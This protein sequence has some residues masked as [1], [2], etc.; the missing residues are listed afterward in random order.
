MTYAVVIL[1]GPEI[2]ITLAGIEYDQWGQ[3]TNHP[4]IV[5]DSWAEGF[6]QATDQGFKQAL[7][8][9]SGTVFVNWTEWNNLLKK[10]P[11]QGLIAHLIW[12]PNSYPYID[13]QCWFANLNNFDIDDLNSNTVTS[14]NPI[15]SDKNLHD[16]YTPLWIKADSTTTTYPVTQFGQGL[17]AKQLNNKRIV[18][19][20][21]NQSRDLKFFCYSGTDVK[22]KIQTVF[23]EYLTLAEQQLWVF[24]NENFS[25]SDQ[26]TL[27]TPGSGLH[28]MFNVIQDS[29][30]HIKIVDISRTQVEFCN[31]LWKYWNGDDYGL[32]S[33]NFIKDNG[34]EHYEID[35]ANLSSVERLMLKKPSR[36]IEYVNDKFK[37]MTI[38]YNIENFQDKWKSATQNKQLTII[39]NNLVHWILAHPEEKNNLW[40]SNILDYKW[41][42]LNTSASDYEKFKNLL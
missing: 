33:Y 6:K 39:N 29:M 18:S 40:V 4:V 5:C 32:F 14:Y 1:A 36:F 23:G 34:L 35:Q 22:A 12:Y 41:T 15:R 24:N 8:V 13:D 11:H 30:H 21:T 42:K 10:Y 37:Q 25:I 28:W 26:S 17:I 19:N 3:K 7:F 27:V 9:R 16:D 38:K 20:W 31:A 2:N